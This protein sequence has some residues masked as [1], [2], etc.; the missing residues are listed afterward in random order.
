MVPYLYQGLRGGGYFTLLQG[1][2]A[3]K[4]QTCRGLDKPV[5][6]PVEAPAL[7]PDAWSVHCHAFFP[8]T[9]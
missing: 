2:H 1:P 7:S 8:A 5:K 9:L 6:E 3:A 4:I